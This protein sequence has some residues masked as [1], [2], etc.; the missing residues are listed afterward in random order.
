M[1]QAS[2]MALDEA[3][4]HVASLAKNAAAFFRISRSIRSRLPSGAGGAQF[5]LHSGKAAVTGKSLIALGLE[6]DLPRAKER[7]AD[8]KGAGRLGDGVAL[9]GDE[10]DRLDLKLARVRSSL[11]GHGWTS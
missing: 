8:V 4:G 1:G 10:F 6:G 3:V 5:L 7:L 2:L 11:S 9:V